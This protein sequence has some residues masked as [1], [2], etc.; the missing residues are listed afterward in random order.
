MTTGS[1]SGT[2]GMSPRSGTTG[3]VAWSCASGGVVC[4]DVSGIDG[5]VVLEAGVGVCG[6]EN[7]GAGGAVS[8]W[9]PVV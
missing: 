9:T 4:A 5:R 2:V 8:V 7:C 3:H 6:M 1:Q